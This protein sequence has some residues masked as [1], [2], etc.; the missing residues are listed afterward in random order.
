MLDNLT[1]VDK[2]KIVE[3]A[4]NLKMYGYRFAAITCDKEREFYELTYHFDLSYNMK[5]L[6]TNVHL[7]DII[8]S[9]STV[10]PAAFLMENEYQDLYGFKFDGLIVDYKGQLYL[11]PDGPKTPMV[12][13][14]TK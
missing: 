2:E 4:N 1:I 12:D 7:T 5:H 10:F 3:E 13:K 9:I 14:D 6:R 11:T 8:K